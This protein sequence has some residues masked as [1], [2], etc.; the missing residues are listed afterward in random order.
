MIDSV[1]YVVSEHIENRSRII[2]IAKNHVKKTDKI[3][4]FGYRMDV[5]KGFYIL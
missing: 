4:L 3:N 5:Y 2:E 1:K